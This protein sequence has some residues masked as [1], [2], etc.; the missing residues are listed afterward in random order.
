MDNYQFV[1]QLA[2]FSQ[3]QQSQS[4][5]DQLTSLLTA[6]SATQATGLL[7]KTVDVNAGSA[8]LS[9]IVKSVSFTAGQPTVTIETSTGQTISSLSISNI[10][11][12]R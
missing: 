3:L 8:T 7:G 1:S 6:Q 11:Q 9:G 12:V 10:A 5:N 4:T 2:Q